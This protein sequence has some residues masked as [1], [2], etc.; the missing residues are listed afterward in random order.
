[1]RRIARAAMLGM[2]LSAGVASVPALADTL[3]L[4]AGVACSFPLHVE[5]TGGRLV[6]REFKDRQGN[7]IRTFTG[8]LGTR[9]TFTNGTSGATL[10]LKSN[11]SVQH[12]TVNQDGSSRYSTT[13][14]NVLILFPSD[15]PAGPSTVLTVGR[16]VFDVDP[17]GTFFLISTTGTSTDICAALAGP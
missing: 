1:M 10:T 5:I 16:T 9:L 17:T 15:V 4:D 12:V 2:A 11:G 6:V 14:H 13:G 3:D 7:V 8:G